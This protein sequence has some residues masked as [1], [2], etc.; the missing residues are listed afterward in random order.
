M[1]SRPPVRRTVTNGTGPSRENAARRRAL[2][3]YRKNQRRKKLKYAVFFAS[4]VLLF[5]AVFVGIAA[6][7][8]LLKINSFPKTSKDP[9]NVF[10]VSVTQEEYSDK[11]KGR[12]LKKE[13]ISVNGTEYV[14]L[15]VLSE[16]ASVAE[17]GDTKTR[18][19][20][21][22]GGS[23]CFDVGTERVKIN[24]GYTY[25][26]SPSLIRDGELCVPTDFFERCLC[27]VKIE[28]DEQL[29]RYVISKTAEPR[30]VMTEQITEDSLSYEDLMLRIRIEREKLL[31]E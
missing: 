10:I 28:T 18:T 13:D 16:Y 27:G 29:D 26:S 11:L 17:G 25:L 14:P 24:G 7:I 31:G 21:L 30:F 19:L 23:A 15:T 12:T 22:A 8:F 4:R 1:N 2:E 3:R 6:L 5:Y 9:K 20:Y